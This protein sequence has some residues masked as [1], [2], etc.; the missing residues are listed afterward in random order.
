VE[1]GGRLCPKAES[2]DGKARCSG[3]LRGE[4]SR[5][6]AELEVVYPR[7]KTR[8]DRQIGRK[9]PEKEEKK[10]EKKRKWGGRCL[11]TPV[12]RGEVSTPRPGRHLEK[13]G[14]RNNTGGPREESLAL[15]QAQ[16]AG[17]AH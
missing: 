13:K 3:R 11:M 1:C 8:R 6:R 17:L 2:G 4:R 7:K 10:K 15:A 14:T 9:S 16:G 12:R 5:E